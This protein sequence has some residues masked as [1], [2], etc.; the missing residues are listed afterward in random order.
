MLKWPIEISMAHGVKISPAKIGYGSF[1]RIS[2]KRDSIF[3]NGNVGFPSRRTFGWGTFRFG[4][5]ESDDFS[6]RKG[7]GNCDLIVFAWNPNDL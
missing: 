3:L 6:V 4:G 7:T 5:A 2:K 1:S